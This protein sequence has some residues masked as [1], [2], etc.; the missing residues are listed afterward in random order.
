MTTPKKERKPPREPK[1]YY[2]DKRTGFY[3]VKLMVEGKNTYICT[4]KTEEEAKAAYK[5]ARAKYSKLQTRKK[6]TP[7][8]K[9]TRNKDY[10]F[11]GTPWYGL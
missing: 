4:K 8:F 10:D 2:I 6:P 11:T 5:E 9:K 7:A 3:K 1:G